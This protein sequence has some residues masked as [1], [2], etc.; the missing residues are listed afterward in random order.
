MRQSAFRLICALVALFVCVAPA[1]AHFQQG[2]Q[3]RTI[4]VARDGD[5]VTAYVRTPAPL[6]FSDV[7][8]EAQATRAPLDTPF[9]RVEWAGANLRYRIGLD[10]ITADEEAFADRLESALAWRQ[11]GQGVAAGLRRYRIIGRAPGEAFDTPDQAR[12]SLEREGARLDPVFGQA[13]VEM[14]LALDAPV[15]EGA[16]EVSAAFPALPLPPGVSIDNHIVDARGDAPS[17]YTIPG[18]LAEGATIDGS[19]V[20]TVAAFVWQGVL[21][22]VEG[23]DHVFLVICLALGVGAP[24]WRLL[25]LVTAFTAGHSLTLVATFLGATP[26]WPWFV[27]AV[28]A[29]I[30]ASVLYASVAAVLKR[31]GSVWIVVGVGLLHGLGFSFVLG[32]ILGRDAPD[33]VPALAAF[34]AGI[35]LGQIAILAATLAVV[36]A[37]TR[38]SARLVTPVRTAV[39]GGIAMM[40]TYWVVER[41][42][43]IA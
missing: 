43:L 15:P 24:T 2:A 34:N 38:L 6:L 41:S 27:P 22:I 13:V 4:V 1:A 21:H 40:A 35:E 29:A 10:A 39:L 9:L 12:R 26:A 42:L 17:S 19:L 33:L 14:E 28:E 16:I 30:A 36:V 31:M 37:L 18:Q 8:R 3:L 23:I 7:V 11:N 32:D 5:G 20:R 25:G